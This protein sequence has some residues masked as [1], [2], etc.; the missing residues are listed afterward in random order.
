VHC[1]LRASCKVQ[2]G[3]SRYWSQKIQVRNH[4]QL[5]QALCDRAAVFVKKRAH[6]LAYQD[7]PTGV[8]SLLSTLVSPSGVQGTSAPGANDLLHICATFSSDPVVMGFAMAFC[9]QKEQSQPGT[10]QQTAAMSDNFLWRLLSEGVM[11]ET[12]HLLP[13]QLHVYYT[14]KV[15]FQRG[16]YNLRKQGKVAVRPLHCYIMFSDIFH[17]RSIMVATYM[18]LQLPE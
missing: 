17:I 7:D 3:G 10:L 12:A 14:F 18:E 11:Q 2:V 5:L 1:G 16:V 13:M 4:G 15:R 9:Q 6:A 8:R